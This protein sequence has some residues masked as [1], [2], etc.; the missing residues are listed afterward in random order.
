MK[1]T[2]YGKLE[3]PAGLRFG[4]VKYEPSLRDTSSNLGSVLGEGNKQPGAE[5]RLGMC[6][7]CSE[8]QQGGSMAQ[9]ELVKELRGKR[10]RW[11]WGG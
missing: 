11:G 6:W 3:M 7:A 1:K 4:I 2:Q 10:K 5:T 9:T 8:V